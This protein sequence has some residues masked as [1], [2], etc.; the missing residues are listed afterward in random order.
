MS[1]WRSPAGSRTA[2]PF[3]GA[4][5]S[6]ATALAAAPSTSALT[7]RPPGP[8]PDTPA[9]FTPSAA[10]T[11]AATGDTRAP[12]GTWAAPR[13]AGLSIDRSVSAS[14]AA[15]AVLEVPGAAEPLPSSLDVRAW[16]APAL[17]DASVAYG[18]PSDHLTDADRLALLGKNLCDRPARG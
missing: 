1:S 15:C 9:R 3:A 13:L 6:S 5:R 12:S 18:Q 4:W 10:A 16:W 11:R 14:A 17:L 2:A 7:I 8:L